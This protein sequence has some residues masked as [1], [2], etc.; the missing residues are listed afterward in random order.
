MIIMRMIHLPAYGSEG[1][2]T[3]GVYLAVHGVIFLPIGTEFLWMSKIIPLRAGE[4]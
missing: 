3:H 1:L 4:A 2:I